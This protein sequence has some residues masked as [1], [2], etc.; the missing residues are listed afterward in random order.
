MEPRAAA[1][2]S[3]VRNHLVIQPCSQHA[4]HNDKPTGPADLARE[5]AGASFHVDEMTEKLAYQMIQR[6]P[7][8][9][10]TNGH[11]YDLTRAQD[12]E[13][14]MRQIARLV[15]LKKTLKHNDPMLVQALFQAMS[16]YSASLSMKIYV[17]EILFQMAINLFG[18]AA[19][20]DR[21][22][23]DLEEWRVIGCFA[24]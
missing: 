23:D 20:Q 10:M 17:H 13:Q 16:V 15:Q 18:T 21:W 5:R 24:M 12:R 1:R 3:A 22:M 2:L 4:I 14:T 11:G 19:Q 6:D 7:D 8:L 9:R